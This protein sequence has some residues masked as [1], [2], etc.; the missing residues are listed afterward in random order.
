MTHVKHLAQF[1]AY[2][3][4]SSLPPKKLYCHHHSI[5]TIITI[6]VLAI[7]SITITARVISSI[8][9]II[10]IF[11]ITV[12]I[13]SLSSSLTSPSLPPP[14]VLL[15]ASSLPLSPS[16]SP[17]P[18]PANGLW[19]SPRHRSAWWVCW[20]AF[21]F[22]ADFLWL[23][24]VQTSTRAFF[25][26]FIVLENKPENCFLPNMVYKYPASGFSTGILECSHQKSS[27]HD[28][29]GWELCPRTVWERSS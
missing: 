21:G 12:T 24:V 3:W 4:C 18:P 11:L 22:E 29:R 2:S 10:I 7:V 27:R 17:P 25:P 15:T 28:P 23:V 26:L 16:S 5:V 6:I 14:S 19:V 13:I 1:L 20:M 8:F 9:I